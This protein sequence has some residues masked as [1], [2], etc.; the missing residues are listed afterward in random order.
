MA[1][2]LQSYCFIWTLLV[3]SYGAPSSSK[4]RNRTL[5]VGGLS[6]NFSSTSA[7]PCEERLQLESMIDRCL[8]VDQGLCVS[9][10]GKESVDAT[11]PIACCCP[12]KMLEGKLSIDTAVLDAPQGMC[13][14][15]SG[16]FVE[17]SIADEAVMKSFNT[18][19]T[20][21]VLTEWKLKDVT[22]V[23]DLHDDFEIYDSKGDIAMRG[24]ATRGYLKLF[25]KW[26]IYDASGKLIMII[27]EKGESAVYKHYEIMDSGGITLATIRVS[28]LAFGTEL[29]MYTGDPVFDWRNRPV[30]EE[31]KVLMTIASP[32]ALSS[33]DGVEVYE[34][35]Y[36]AK[37]VTVGDEGAWKW[38][39]NLGGHNL[40]SIQVAPGRSVK[41]LIAGMIV[42]DE[43]VEDMTVCVIQ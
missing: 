11:D 39:T 28:A 43:V 18:G 38:T 23:N 26:D 14:C 24:H 7:F 33:T 12:F 27:A 13:R 2:A 20:Y 10:I 8:K 6:S 32:H 34:G 15:G 25:D 31:T 22:G 36:G 1:F 9:R 16:E 4:P 17:K 37:S 29:Y 5:I 40:Y 35:D 42:F 19:W 21:D 3:N 30:N 41:L